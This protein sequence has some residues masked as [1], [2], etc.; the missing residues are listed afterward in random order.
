MLLKESMV[1]DYLEMYLKRLRQITLKA[2]FTY[3]NSS[4]KCTDVTGTVRST[5]SHWEVS[6]KSFQKSGSTATGTAT[7][8]QLM[9]G[10]VVKTTTKKISIHCSP[11]GKISQI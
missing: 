9:S 1:K 4:A 6:S 2:T 10:K 3:N 8:K 7:V 11:T 5:N